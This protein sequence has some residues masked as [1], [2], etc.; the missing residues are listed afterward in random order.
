M[1]TEDE[2][3][4]LWI[5]Y[6]GWLALLV[7]IVYRTPPAFIFLLFI[8]PGAYSTFVPL[9]VALVAALAAAA[10][11]IASAK[12]G[13]PNSRRTQ[14][15]IG[16]AALGLVAELVVYREIAASWRWGFG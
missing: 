14:I 8:K 3:A 13:R 12:A 5:G 15:V 16:V 10:G 7:A 11:A 6:L 9:T 1:S 2:A 4:P